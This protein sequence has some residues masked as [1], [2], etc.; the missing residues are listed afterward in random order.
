MEAAESSGAESDDGAGFSCSVN[1][2]AEGAKGHGLAFESTSVKETGALATQA[3][4][5]LCDMQNAAV[6]C[7]SK[8]AWRST[9]LMVYP[10][11]ISVVHY[12]SKCT[13]IDTA[14]RLLC[15]P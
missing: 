2:R 8:Q 3:C 12:C 6:L 11:I 15:A 4:I 10:L 14:M 1:T 9:S 7:A 13:T 5:S